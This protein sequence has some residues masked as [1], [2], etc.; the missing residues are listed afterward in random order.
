MHS[1]GAMNPNHVVNKNKS[2][3]NSSWRSVVKHNKIQLMLSFKIFLESKSVTFGAV[4]M[5]GS[6]VW[7]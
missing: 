6:S 1:K 5:R 4:C 7:L 3:A 2:I